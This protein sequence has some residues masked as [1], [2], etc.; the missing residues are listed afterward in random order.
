MPITRTT[1]IDDDGTGTTGTI[2]NNAWLQTIYGQIDAADAAAIA[3]PYRVIETEMPAGVLDYSDYNPA[4]G[5]VGHTIILIGLVNATQT[6]YGFK[7]AAPAFPGQRILVY[8]VADGS[9]ALNFFHEHPAQSANSKLTLRGSPSVTISGFW[10][11]AEFHYVTY[12]GTGRWLM[13]GFGKGIGGAVRE[14]VPINV[15][16]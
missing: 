3:A 1:M 14:D 8:T 12:Q 15:P 9:Y 4:P 5:I 11:Y 7:P 2:L 13:A 16:V 10:A 6:I